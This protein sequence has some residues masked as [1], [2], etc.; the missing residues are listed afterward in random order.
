MHLELQL[1]RIVVLTG[2]I[3]LAHSRHYKTDTSLRRRGYLVL[4]PAFLYSF[5]LPLHKTDIS[6]GKIYQEPITRSEQLP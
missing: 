6:R 4:V 5:K 2:Q 3:S 1:I